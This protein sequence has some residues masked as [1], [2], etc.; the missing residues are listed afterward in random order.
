[1]TWK[2]ETTVVSPALYLLG[3]YEILLREWT[4][5]RNRVALVIRITYVVL[6][7]AVRS[8]RQGFIIRSLSCKAQKLR[9]KGKS[10]AHRW[11]EDKFGQEHLWINGGDA[12][13][14][15]SCYL[16]PS[17]PSRR[18]A[19]QSWHQEKNNKKAGDHVTLAYLSKIIVRKFTLKGYFA[20]FLRCTE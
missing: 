4:I 17:Q 11:W 8:R 9:L 13:W 2:P 16:Q 19:M 3:D 7:R 5:F 12:H 20:T 10:D 14:K 18:R 6:I 1:M 15:S